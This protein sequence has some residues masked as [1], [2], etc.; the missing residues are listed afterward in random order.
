MVTRNGSE[1][2]LIRQNDQNNSQ[3]LPASDWTDLTTN[4]QHTG[5]PTL[6]PWLHMCIYCTQAIEIK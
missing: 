5:D 4:L 2:T 6:S 3:S 1:K